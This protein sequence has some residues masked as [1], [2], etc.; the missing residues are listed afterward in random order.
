MSRLPSYQW[1][2]EDT[3][4]EFQAELTE[5]DLALQE[6]DTALQE[7]DSLLK[8]TLQEK[9]QQ[10]VRLIRKMHLSGMDAATIADLL[11]MPLAE[12]VALFKND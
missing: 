11:E 4:K 5:K 10:T 1:G 2:R 7:K 8:Q 12:V 9:E 6:K 3:L